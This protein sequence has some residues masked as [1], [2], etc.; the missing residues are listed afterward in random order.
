MS[1]LHYSTNKASL[2]NLSL[3]GFFVGWPNPPSEEALRKILH[4][5][6]HIC[7]AIQNQKL[8]GFINA[9]S[10]QVLSAY[11]PLLEVLPEFQKMGIGRELVKRMKSELTRY[12]MI[13]VTCDE[14]VTSFY[15]PLGFRQGTAMMIRNYQNQDGA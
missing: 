12:Y 9:I 11:I 15:G 2:T 10:D 7:L 4:N 5:S 8:V 14:N 3:A 1:E 13:D 6:Q